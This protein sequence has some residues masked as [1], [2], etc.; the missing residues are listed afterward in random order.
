MAQCEHAGS[1]QGQTSFS[2]HYSLQ[3]LT[4]LGLKWPCQLGAGSLQLA[5]CFG[6]SLRSHL[7][8]FSATLLLVVTHGRQQAQL[9]TA[10]TLS[11][12]QETGVFPVGC[13]CRHRCCCHCYLMKHRAC[14]LPE[15]LLAQHS[16]VV[17]ILWCQGS[18]LGP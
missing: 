1:L 12:A 6:G 3:R 8:W 16:V 9:C 4:C 5:P 13:C 10:L 7:R 17:I 15:H 2:G 11:R 18:N 14:C